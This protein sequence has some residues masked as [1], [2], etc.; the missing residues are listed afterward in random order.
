MHLAM[1][2][3]ASISFLS[4]AAARIGENSLIDFLGEELRKVSVRGA[5]SGKNCVLV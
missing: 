4:L 1:V 3:M 5:R 2:G